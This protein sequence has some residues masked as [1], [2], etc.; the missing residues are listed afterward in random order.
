MEIGVTAASARAVALQANRPQALSIQGVHPK[1]IDRAT[2]LIRVTHNLE[3]TAD[4][5]TNIC[6]WVVLLVTGGMLEIGASRHWPGGRASVSH[7]GLAI[8]SGTC[9]SGE[10]DCSPEWSTPG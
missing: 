2:R 1:T 8:E 6:G 4:H 9:R 7:L 10:A 5:S 3:R